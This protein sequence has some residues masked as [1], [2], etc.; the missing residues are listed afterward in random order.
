M[1]GTMKKVLFSWKSWFWSLHKYN[2]LVLKLVVSIL[3]VGLGFRLIFCRS[4]G[5][6][7]DPDG[8]FSRAKFAPLP[9]G[10]SRTNTAPPPVNLSLQGNAEFT[11]SKG[12]QIHVFFFL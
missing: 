5:F 9:V 6:S 4:N 7:L 3:L 12:T 2:Y 10:P 11:P 1:T 8:P